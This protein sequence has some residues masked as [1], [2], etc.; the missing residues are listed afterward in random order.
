[1]ISNSIV[2]LN[3]IISY[4]FGRVFYYTVSNENENNIFIFA[5]ELRRRGKKKKKRIIFNKRSN[6]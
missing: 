5:K 3:I 4:I 1:M 2:I 6:V